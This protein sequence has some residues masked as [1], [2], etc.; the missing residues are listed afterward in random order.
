MAALVP[1][2]TPHPPAWFL[3]WT[4]WAW[5]Q[6]A[7]KTPSC[8]QTLP[9]DGPS[10]Q[11]MTRQL[12]TAEDGSVLS[13]PTELPPAPQWV[14]LLD[15]T[16]VCRDRGP[17]QCG[18][19]MCGRCCLV[20]HREGQPQTHVALAPPHSAEPR[21]AFLPGALQGCGAPWAQGP[22]QATSHQ[23]INTF[24]NQSTDTFRE[25][26]RWCRVLDPWA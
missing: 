26:I 5:C 4:W 10:L 12:P 6:E 9:L 14:L 23:S 19:D 2:V 22:A 15:R 13:H 17:W 8:S 25:H 20:V 3:L 21:N 7:H 16:A 11:R 1:A 24:V 18:W